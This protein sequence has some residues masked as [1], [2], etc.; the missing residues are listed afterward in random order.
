MILLSIYSIIDRV[1]YSD[2]TL[3]ENKEERAKKIEEMKQEI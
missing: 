2:I 3:N 1:D